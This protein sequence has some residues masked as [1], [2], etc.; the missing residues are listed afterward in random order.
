MKSTYD[1]DKQQWRFWPIICLSFLYPI[2][3]SLIGLAIPLYYFK[4]GVPIQII[5]L[6]AASITI[7]YCFS[8]ILFNRFSDRIGR[9]K[10]IGIALLGTSL[11]QLIFYF[12]LEPSIFFIAR[13]IEGLVMGLYW[14]NLQATISENANHN[15]NKYIAKFN[16]AWNSG[17][18]SGFLL[19]ALILFRIDDLT[20]IFYIAP[21][22]V[23]IGLI[24]TILFFREAHPNNLKTIELD[25]SDLAANLNSKTK[26]REILGIYVPLLLPI[27]FVVAFSFQKSSLNLLYSIKSELLGFDTYT[28]YLLAF[29]SLTTQLFSTSLSSYLSIKA[30]KRISIVC[31]IV[32]IIINF[33]FAINSNFLIFVALFFI[34]GFFAGIIYSFG[35]K[36]SILLNAK[37][38]TSR[39]SSICES[40]MG[41]TFLVI[42]IMSAY[43]ATIN[44]DYGFFA[45]SFGFVLFLMVSLIF[46]KKLKS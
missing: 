25:E 8:P 45:I 43:I 17:V 32:L 41:L 23:F 9:K 33:L 34:M 15:P 39:Y 42:P 6:L 27:L 11:A 44:I 13:L 38:Q 40:S 35:L 16:F 2:N 4:Q 37:H 18:L 5:G 28:V 24:I 31:L 3:N 12:T 29:F 1:E 36:L 20:I 46:L 10:S 19:G 26:N 30:L 7:T 21:I 22:L 14:A